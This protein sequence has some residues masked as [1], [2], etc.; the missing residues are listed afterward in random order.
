[1]R[2][3]TLG[4][5]ICLIAIRL[6][7][8]S[9]LYEQFFRGN[10]LII[11]Q[12]MIAGDLMT[13]KVISRNTWQEMLIRK[14]SFFVIETVFDKNKFKVNAYRRLENSK[15]SIDATS[16]QENILE[17]QN[18]IYDPI[19]NQSITLEAFNQYNCDDLQH[20]KGIGIKTAQAIMLYRENNGPFM[21]F[22]ELTEVKGIGEKKLNQ[23]FITENE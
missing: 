17:T 22:E 21:A 19:L 4:L 13:D 9:P 2:H 1:M 12:Q 3:L 11:E 23:L 6:I 15:G 18:M 14:Q 7:I 10:G 8:L 5:F 16:V 20:F